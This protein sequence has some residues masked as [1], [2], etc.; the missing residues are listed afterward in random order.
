MGLTYI[1]TPSRAKIAGMVGGA[2]AITAYI[3]TKKDGLFRKDTTVLMRNFS[4]ATIVI[5]GWGVGIY[6]TEAMYMIME[7]DV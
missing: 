7:K 2:C 4:R 6:G 3:M 1:D 5:C